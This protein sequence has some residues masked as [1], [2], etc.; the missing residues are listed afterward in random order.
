ML[1]HASIPVLSGSRS[2]ANKDMTLHSPECKHKSV[3]T[4]RSLVS[5]PGHL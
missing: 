3:T 2:N 5:Y 4:G 1:T